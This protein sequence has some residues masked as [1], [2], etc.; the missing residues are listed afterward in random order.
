MVTVRSPG[1]GA[2]LIRAVDAGGRQAPRA[3]GGV[4]S[5]VDQKGTFLFDAQVHKANPDLEP[6]EESRLLRMTV[7][8]WGQVYRI[9]D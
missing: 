7:Q 2:H 6:V 8:A 1:A 5:Q 4:S 9:T 3:A